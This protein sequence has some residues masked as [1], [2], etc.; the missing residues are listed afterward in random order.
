MLHNTSIFSLEVGLVTDAFSRL[1]NPPTHIIF[2]FFHILRMSSSQS[3]FIF[4]RWVC[5]TTNQLFFRWGLLYHQHTIYPIMILS[6]YHHQPAMFY[7]S[8][9]SMDYPY[10]NHINEPLYPI[11][12]HSL[13]STTGPFHGS[14][15]VA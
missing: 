11:M 9:I 12:I 7:I 2:Y 3:T 4:F 8:Y 10:I 6:L 5:Y 13:S 14:G 15:H 1:P